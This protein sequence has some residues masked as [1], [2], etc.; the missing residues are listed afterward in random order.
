MYSPRW[1]VWN[2]IDSSGFSPR[3]EARDARMK[4]SAIMAPM[5]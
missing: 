2:I 1:S 3:V 4:P 5:M